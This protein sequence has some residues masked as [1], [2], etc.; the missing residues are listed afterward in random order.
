MDGN[1]FLPEVQLVDCHPVLKDFSSH[2]LE[3]VPVLSVVVVQHVQVF[4]SES[5][6][7]AAEAP[8]GTDSD[9]RKL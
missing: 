6:G 8:A 3:P 1:I 4:P 2:E 9:G 5:P 7:V